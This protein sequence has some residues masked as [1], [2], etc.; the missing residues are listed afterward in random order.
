MA[1]IDWEAGQ[2]SSPA[3][4][5]KARWHALAQAQR[6]YLHTLDQL[7]LWDRQTARL[8][9]FKNRE[10]RTDRDIVLI[11]TTDM[12]QAVRQMLDQVADRIT[13][14]IFA[15]ESWSSRFDTHGCVDP[16][17][18][19]Q[20]A[21]ELRDD[22]IRVVDGPTDQCRAV[23]ETLASWNGQ[24]RADQITIGVPDE[25][26]IP[27]LQRQ[28]AGASLPTRYVVGQHMA[29]APEIGRAHV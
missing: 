27:Y 17:A 21:I 19:E 29:E 12:N 1:A 11:G 16:Q 10:C 26:L 23:I 18:W 5:E 20:A 14:L 22:Q 3:Q 15:P 25:G 28:F 8:Y 2:A 9:A 6:A 24:F 7:S 13:T 4:R